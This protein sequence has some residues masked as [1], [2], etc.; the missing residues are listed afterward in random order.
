MWKALSTNGEVMATSNATKQTLLLG[1][2]SWTIFHDSVECQEK[3]GD[4]YIIELNF[5]TCKDD[6]FNC[7][8]GNC[9]DILKLCD[10]QINCHD[11]SDEDQCS[12]IRKESSYTRHL[13]PQKNNTLKASIYI[14]AEILDI[15]EIK[16]VEG[17]IWIKIN[18]TVTWLDYRL[19]FYNLQRQIR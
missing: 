3:Y 12:L 16:E 19:N 9:I 15:Y 7:N 6:Q 2:Q 5:N 8:D 13:S 11:T 4:P 10:G 1:I 14:S 18:I 17:T